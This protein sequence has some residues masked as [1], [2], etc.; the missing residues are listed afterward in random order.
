MKIFVLEDEFERIKWFKSVFSDCE[1]DITDKVAEACEYLQKKQ[2]D[3][4]FLDRD[5]SHPTETGEDVVLEMKEKKLNQNAAVIIHSMNIIGQKTMMRGLKEY[6][7]NVS[8]VDFCNLM[9]T[10]R[11]DFD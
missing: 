8:Q 6:H 4:I 1:I 10:K 5:L 11:K 3:W 7:N 2:Y 9:K